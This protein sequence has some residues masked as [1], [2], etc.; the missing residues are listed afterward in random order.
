MKRWINYIFLIVGLGITGQGCYE[1]DKLT[2]SG[3]E[4]LLSEYDLP[5]GTHD[6]D[7]RI[8]EYWN[9]YGLLAFYRFADKEFWWT[10]TADIR[11]KP[12]DGLEGGTSK[13]YEGVQADE[14]YVGHLVKML[15]EEFFAFYTKEYLNKRMPKKFL[16]MG[17]LFSVP[18]SAMAPEF[19][20]RFRIYTHVGYDR[21]AI[22]MANEDILEMTEDSVRNFRNELNNSF[23]MW[24][25]NSGF[26]EFSPEFLAITDYTASYATSNETAIRNFYG[27][28][29]IDVKAKIPENDW[30]AYITAIVTHTYEELTGEIDPVIYVNGRFNA[31]KWS[32]A[33]DPC[34]GMLNRDSKKGWDKAGKINEKYDIITSY[35]KKKYNLDLQAIGNGEKV[36]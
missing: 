3:V 34:L 15:D 8:M 20:S 26:I 29:L 32:S 7:D 9:D 19:A 1:E 31:T 14:D 4:P 12:M 30:K 6:Y 17:E 2:A 35:F 24:Q 16:L 28:G 21:I 18:S 36:E 22:N 23:L 27:A 33:A 5:Q 10:P 11:P 25:I 13:G